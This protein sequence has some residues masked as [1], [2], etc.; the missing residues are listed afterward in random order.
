M[1]RTPGA[2][3]GVPSVFYPSAVDQQ[4]SPRNTTSSKN[5]YRKTFKVVLT[6]ISSEEVIV[7]TLGG[8]WQSTIQNPFMVSWMCELL[9]GNKFKYQNFMVISRGDLKLENFSASL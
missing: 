5:Q 2:E 9:N 7:L 3:P 8:G 1:V 6:Y 4:N